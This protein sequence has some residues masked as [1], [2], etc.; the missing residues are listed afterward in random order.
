[1]ILMH[2]LCTEIN[3]AHFP[4]C[5][6]SAQHGNLGQFYTTSSQCVWKALSHAKYKQQMNP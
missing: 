1:M 4:K 2:I 3:Y 6:A 5:K